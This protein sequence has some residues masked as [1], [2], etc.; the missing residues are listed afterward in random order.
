METLITGLVFFGFVVVV[1]IGVRILRE[2]EVDTFHSVL[3]LSGQAAPIDLAKGRV[4]RTPIGG[5]AE[6]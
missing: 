6:T 1:G 4:E 5:D 3:I 2:V